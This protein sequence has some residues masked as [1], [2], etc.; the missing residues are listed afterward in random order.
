MAERPAKKSYSPGLEGVPAGITAISEVDPRKKKLAYRG[1]DIEALARHSTYEEV[2]YLLL[3]GELPTERELAAFH[4]DLAAERD[5]PPAVYDMLRAAIPSADP[6]DVLR[7]VVS[8][9]AAWDPDA[10]HNDHAANMRKAKRLIAKMATAVAAHFRF[11]RGLR[12]VPPAADLSHAANFFHMI[13][14]SRPDE[15]QARAFD[16]SL[17]LYAE[18]GFNASTFTA[19][20][21]ASTLADMHAAVSAA[22]GALKGP[23][24]GGANE[25][26]MEM[27]LEVGDPSKAEAWVREALAAKRRIMGFGHRVYRWGDS[28]VPTMKAIARSLAEALGEKRWID[29]AR[30]I[31]RLMEKEK[32]LYPNV[33]FPCGY[34]YYML[35]LPIKLYT[36]IFAASR[37]AGWAAHVIEQ[38][39]NNRLIRPDAIYKGHRRRAY[40]PLARRKRGADGTAA[41]TGRA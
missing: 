16:V 10:R 15:R 25:R 23:L 40:V 20:V 27:L 30:V 28:R 14:G 5:L 3:V 11:T 37:I 39:D 38:H 21:V 29:M 4:N 22:I 12:P 7:A 35:G 17:I 2:A 6:M 36:P 33:D 34:V 19:R 24:H 32:G 1:L 8:L 9:L 13:Q 26:V 18:H 31:E 41:S